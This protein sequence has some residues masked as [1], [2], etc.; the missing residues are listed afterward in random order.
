MA[1]TLN[2][3]YVGAVA[4]IA[5]K[6]LGATDPSETQ[7]NRRTEPVRLGYLVSS[8]GVAHLC[9]YDPVTDSITFEDG[10]FVAIQK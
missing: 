7:S 2:A 5:R 3:T 4:D 9:Y 8:T 6:A 10:D 1:L